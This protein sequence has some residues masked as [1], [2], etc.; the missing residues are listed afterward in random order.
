MFSV[1]TKAQSRRFLKSVFETLRFL[2]M[3]KLSKQPDDDPAAIRWINS[4][5]I[6][7]TYNMKDAK[8]ETDKTG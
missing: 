1:H 3:F 5:L 2:K 7:F 6:G 4:D 8:A